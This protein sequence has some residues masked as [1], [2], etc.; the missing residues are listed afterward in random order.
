MLNEMTNFSNN[1]SSIPQY[2]KDLSKKGES[3]LEQMKDVEVPESMVDS[4]VKGLQLANYM[5]S[6]GKE[7][8]NQTNDPVAMIVS[9]SKM[10]TLLHLT[11]SLVV[12][13]QSKLESLGIK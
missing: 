4:H 3:A 9:V 12:E 10:S 1:T 7:T 5:I 13:N 2:F 11:E 6:L 8:T